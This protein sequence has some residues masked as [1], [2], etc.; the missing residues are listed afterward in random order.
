M[1]RKL[2]YL[3]AILVLPLILAVSCEYIMHDEDDIYNSSE[4]ESFVENPLMDPSATRLWT[5]PVDPNADGPLTISFKA[6]RNSALKGYTG[7][8]Y[9]H[10]G[11]LE[12]GVWK[13]VQA[14]WNVNL[15][16]C[17][18][19]KDE[20]EQ[21]TWHLELQPSIRESFQSGTTAVTRIGIVIRSADGSMKGIA[22]DSFIDV[23]DD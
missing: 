4:N 1:I 13:Y 18:F 12:F 14:D 17:R 2:L 6:G 9:A 22:E 20:K 10:I 7:D 5:N 11:I 19:R 23:T 15:P 3:Y 21:D 8:V 16:H